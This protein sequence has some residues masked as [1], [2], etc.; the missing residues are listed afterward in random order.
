MK[1][2][3]VIDKSKNEFKYYCPDDE[4]DLFIEES[5]MDGIWGDPDTFDLSVE[6]YKEGDE[7]SF[8]KL[9]H[10]VRASSTTGTSW[11][12]K[13]K[14]ITDD[15]P[16]GTYRIGWTYAYKVEA[17]DERLIPIFRARIRINDLI[18]VRQIKSQIIS[19]ANAIPSVGF[20][21]WE[22]S[23]VT[24]IVFEFRR[25]GDEGTVSVSDVILE[26]WKVSDLAGI[27]PIESGS[28]ELVKNGIEVIAMRVI[29]L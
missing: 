17:S 24:D 22:L 8:F 10:S 12:A 16:L 19:G 3:I 7:R 9:V 18:D 6:E 27:A 28:E 2:I 15:L 11:I 4:T 13:L 20:T 14:M 26:L 23:G 1:K 5:T 29:K 21:Y 25:L